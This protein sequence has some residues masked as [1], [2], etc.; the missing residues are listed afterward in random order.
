V[1]QCVDDVKLGAMCT[2]PELP[3]FHGQVGRQWQLWENGPA[4]KPWAGSLSSTY[5]DGFAIPIKSN[6]L[7][8]ST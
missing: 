4:S 6:D 5:K 7:V 2:R 3:Q 1:V 8:K